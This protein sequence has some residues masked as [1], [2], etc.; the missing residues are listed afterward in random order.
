M[1]VWMY[2]CKICLKSFKSSRA[3]RSHQNWHNENYALAHK[4]INAVNIVKANKK[5]RQDNINEYLKNSKHC[6]NCTLALEYDKRHNDFC[7]TSCRTTY[8]NIRRTKDVYVKVANK[9]KKDPK[10]YP[11]TCNN[12]KQIFQSTK[13]TQKFCCVKCAS[14][15]SAT[16]ASQVLKGN[17]VYA[18]AQ[19]ERLKSQY[20][21]GRKVYGGRTKWFE[22]KD[23]KVQGTYELRTCKILDKLKDNNEIYDWIYTNDRFPYINETGKL[24]TYIIDFKIYTEPEKYYYLEVKGF[25]TN[26]DILK[27]KAVRDAGFKL[28]IWKQKDIELHETFVNIV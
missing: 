9:L 14:K 7:S 28:E 11:K 24:S 4:T 15:H 25:V 19:S 10:V 3:L 22:Y 17:T 2:E 12:C 18:L 26:N 6:K 20:K 13:K 8:C 23:I 16:V 1:V 21:N 27:W 5:Y